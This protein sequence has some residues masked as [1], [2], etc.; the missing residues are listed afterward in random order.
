MLR[1]SPVPMVSE[2][3]SAAEFACRCCGQIVLNERN[4]LLFQSLETIRSQVGGRPVVMD[5]GCRCKAHNAA[6]GG[7][8]SSKHLEGIAADVHVAGMTPAQLAQIVRAHCPDVMGIG[9]G[10]SQFHIDVRPGPRTEWTYPLRRPG[11]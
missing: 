9:V 4:W 6:V 2:H 8:P 7:A 5:S 1:I 10:A 3:F 11:G